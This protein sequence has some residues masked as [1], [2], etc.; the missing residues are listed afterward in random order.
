MTTRLRKDATL[1]AERLRAELKPSTILLFGSVARGSDTEGS[2]LDLCLLF[3]EM[4]G[5]KL[6]VM[7]KARNISRPVHKGAVDIVAY[8]REEWEAYIAAGSSFELMLK[9]E[10]VAL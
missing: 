10:A 4:P 6:D 3:D 1:I 5:R 7:R 8:S 2:D 9:R